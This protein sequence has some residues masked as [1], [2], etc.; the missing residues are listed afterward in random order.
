MSLLPRAILLANIKLITIGESS[1]RRRINANK[2]EKLT[3][4]SRSGF[5]RRTG[6]DGQRP[7]PNPH[8]SR[9]GFNRETTEYRKGLYYGTGWRICR[10]SR[11]D[12]WR[13]GIH[14]L[15]FGAPAHLYRRPRV[16]G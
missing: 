16:A 2:A 15:E 5:W 11:V 9:L 3:T 7:R 14:R 1:G 4:R 8:I 6:Q 12:H 10:S 13:A